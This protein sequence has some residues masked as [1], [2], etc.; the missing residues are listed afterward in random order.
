MSEF[1]DIAELIVPSDTVAFYGKVY[2]VHGLSASHLI[3]IV[4]THGAALAPLYEQ[5]TA[6]RLPADLSAVAV[7]L[8]D[9][10]TSL[11]GTV[12][13]CGMGRPD[14]AAK[15]STLPFAAQLD[16]LDKIV[17][18]TLEVEGGLGK[19]VEIVTKAARDLAP[20]RPQKP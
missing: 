11:A 20:L 14:Q 15:C 3:H 1:D 10:F 13:A 8:G 18:L 6:G 9:S 16:A 2:Q 5:A 19:V 17:R 7:E 4:R 12:I